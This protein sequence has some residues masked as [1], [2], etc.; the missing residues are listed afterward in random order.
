MQSDEN[1]RHFKRRHAYICTVPFTTASG[2]S[3]NAVVGM[4]IE[5]RGFV[6]QLQCESAAKLLVIV[7]AENKG[8]KIRGLEL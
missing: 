6:S 4:N 2:L 8:S 1:N 7:I 3:R 5:R